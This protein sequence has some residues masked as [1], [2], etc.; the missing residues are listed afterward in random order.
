MPRDDAPALL[1]VAQAATLLGVHPNTIRTWTD[2]GRLTAYRINARGD[3]RFRRGDVERLLVE[4]R[5]ADDGR[6]RPTRA[7][8]RSAAASSRVFGR[9]AA[10]LAVIADDGVGGPRGRRGAAHRA[11]RRPRGDLRRRGRA[12][13]SSPPT[14]GST[15]LRR[16]SRA[17]PSRRRPT[18]T[19]D[20]AARHAARADRPARPRRARRPPGCRR[21][22]G[23]RWRRRWRPTLASTRLLGRARREL[24]RAR[25]L[26]SVTKELTGTL[27][28][29]AVLGRGRRPHPLAVR[30][31]QGRASGW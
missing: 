25:A 1:T 17:A 20:R 5:P 18:T 31:R 15:T 6:S 11:R 4:D 29:A 26:R 12:A 7:P 16:V 10:G 3:R 14:P 24:Q 8:T 22:S 30:G 13:S 9:I 2:A 27:D 23:A 19:S 28:L 21:S